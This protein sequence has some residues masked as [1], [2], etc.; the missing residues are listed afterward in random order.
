MIGVDTNVFLRFAIDDDP[1]QHRAARNLLARADA[2]NPIM[3]HPIV[4]LE[5]EWVLRSHFKLDRA[6][7]ADRLAIAIHGDRFVMPDTDACEAALADY[8]NNL[9]DLAECLI[10]RLNQAAGCSTTL[11]FDKKASRIPGADPL[12][13]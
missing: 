10:V 8:R 4:W 3:I 6:A 7:I 5:A 11:T 1:A 12:N 13:L 2:A 9:A